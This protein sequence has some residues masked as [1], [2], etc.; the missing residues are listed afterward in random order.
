MLTLRSI[1]YA[2]T[3]N[4]AIAGHTRSKVAHIV[5]GTVGGAVG[6]IIIAAV[7]FL[8]CQ[9]R[10]RADSDNSIIERPED[11][12]EPTTLESS[13]SQVA[14]RKIDDPDRKLDDGTL[15][16]IQKGSGFDSVL[17]SSAPVQSVNASDVRPISEPDGDKTLRMTTSLSPE[18]RFRASP[19]Q[20][21]SEASI[22]FAIH[23]PSDNGCEELVLSPPLEARQ[24]YGQDPP[25]LRKW[26]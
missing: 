18:A 3:N 1:S 8:L 20:H 26:I 2:T 25:A 9:R 11:E 21:V 19:D 23:N 12:K 22:P 15:P 10:H 7:L 17:S 16:T 24:I 6:L 5:G 14:I 4:P 13:K